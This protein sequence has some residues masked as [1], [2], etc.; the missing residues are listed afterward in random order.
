MLMV[1]ICLSFIF[2]FVC[3]IKAIVSERKMLKMA[4][5]GNSRKHQAGIAKDTPEKKP[6]FRYWEIAFRKFWKIIDVNMLLAAGC[7]P[8][9]GAAAIMYYFSEKYAST[10]FLI[11][12]VLVIVFAVCFGPLIAAC[13]Q[14]LRNFARE[15]PMFLMNT[16][17]KTFKNNFKQACTGQGRH[18]GLAGGKRR[19]PR[20]CR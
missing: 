19:G 1:W 16:F 20:S 14:I 15:K 6:F 2:K 8:L 3:F 12:A 11:A 9:I 4:L 17:F 10:A 7:L 13:T 5:F 18:C